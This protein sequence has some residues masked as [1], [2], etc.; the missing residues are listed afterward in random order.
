MKLVIY[1]DNRHYSSVAEEK[2]LWFNKRRASLRQNLQ[3]IISSGSVQRSCGPL[4][5]KAAH[6][7]GR[8]TWQ[9]LCKR[10]PG[11]AHLKVMEVSWGSALWEAREGYWG[12]CSL[13]GYE[14][15]SILEMSGSWAD[16][17]GQQPVQSGVNLSLLK[18]L[19]ILW[20]A[21]WRNETVKLLWSQEDHKWAPGFG[22]WTFHIVIL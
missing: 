18:N 2:K 13:H 19:P 10:I 6:R 5:G 8:R 12:R 9:I 1:W 14:D 11:D 4:Q 21:N 3:K 16:H 22:S 15:S 17:Q 7:A 20:V